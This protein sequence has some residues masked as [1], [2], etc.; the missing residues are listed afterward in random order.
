MVQTG[1]SELQTFGCPKILELPLLNSKAQASSKRK[2]NLQILGAEKKSDHSKG[3]LGPVVWKIP[4]FC[5]TPNARVVTFL[6]AKPAIDELCSYGT[7]WKVRYD[8]SLIC[9]PLTAKCNSNANGNARPQA[10]AKAKVTSAEVAP[11]VWMPYD[12]RTG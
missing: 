3:Q 5:S 1:R 7:I 2:K 8:S 10:K 6:E 12:S 11:S 4:Q 9:D